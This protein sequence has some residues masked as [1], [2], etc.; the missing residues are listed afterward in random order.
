M[1]SRLVG[2][3]VLLLALSASALT[4]CAS[5]DAGPVVSQERAVPDVAAVELDT[6][7]DLT[8]TLGATPAL[9]VT[10]GERV[11]E[12]LTAHVEGGVLRLG[13]NGEPVL[14]NG[15]IRY[16]LTVSSLESLVVQGS[17]DARIDLSGAIAPTV[18]VR[19]S[20]DVEA[21][22][23]DAATAV[24]RVD[25]AGEIVAHDTVVEDLTVRIDGSGTVAIDGTAR[26]QDVSI[27]GSGEHTAED[28]RSEDA[29]VSIRGSGSADV[30]V[31]GNLAVVIDGSGDVSYGGEARV[32]QEIAG[33][34]DV[35][36]R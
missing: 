7:G 16:E 30:T 4:G 35:R 25:G 18:T 8:V 28:L 21:T 13:M 33:S 10:A 2:S 6:S 19:G 20:G 22:G 27:R 3:S 1:R 9:T 26:S 32:T 34:G 14:R 36:R 23:I 31:D 11:I 24:L 15:E 5:F 17:G 29:F 12:H